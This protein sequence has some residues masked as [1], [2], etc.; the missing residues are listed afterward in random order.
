[1][2]T[3]DI[4]RKYENGEA[5]SY[6]VGCFYE[7]EDELS[8]DGMTAN[9]DLCL[10]CRGKVEEEIRNLID[11]LRASL[12]VDD[13]RAS[14]D[15]RSATPTYRKGPARDRPRQPARAAEAVELFEDDK[16]D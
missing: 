7:E 3:C 13:L 8:V 5:K 2:L 15:E 14:L 11:R 4:C 10:E 9:V 1:M 6:Q 12:G 16:D